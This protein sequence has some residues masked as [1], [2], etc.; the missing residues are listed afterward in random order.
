MSEVTGRL[1]ERWPGGKRREKI[2]VVIAGG[3]G[4]G[5]EVR[6]MADKSKL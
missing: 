4:G 5:G 3:A 2:W 1:R 6:V